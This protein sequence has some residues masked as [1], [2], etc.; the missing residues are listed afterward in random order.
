MAVRNNN[1]VPCTSQYIKNNQSKL[2]N[3][4]VQNENNLQYNYNTTGND[5]I[6]KGDKNNT[7]YS[8]NVS[9]IGPS[10]IEITTEQ[11]LK[12]DIQV[13]HAQSSDGTGQKQAIPCKRV[14]FETGQIGWMPLSMDQLMEI[15]N[16]PPKEIPEQIQGNV[17]TNIVSTPA[18]VVV[19][20][21]ASPINNI[22]QT[23]IME[24]QNIENCDSDDKT[25]YVNPKQFERIMKRREARMKLLQEGRLPKERQKY[26][27][28]SRH[29]HALKRVRGEGGKFDTGNESFAGDE[30]S[31]SPNTKKLCEEEGEDEEDDC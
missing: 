1:S 21:V 20:V 29:K 25:I 15:I 12:Y 27:H 19:Q 17:N 4:R 23:Q 2:Y 8:N 31:L 13:F 10:H 30:E 6:N 26:L 11:L 16:N 22:S 24:T 9:S 28:E 3:N 5:S 7:T 14:I 18:P